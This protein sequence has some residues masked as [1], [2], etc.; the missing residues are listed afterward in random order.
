MS[1]VEWSMGVERHIT[2][3]KV[4]YCEKACVRAHRA[5]PTPCIACHWF[6]QANWCDS[7][8]QIACPHILL[9]VN[10]GKVHCYGAHIKYN[11]ITLWCATC[12]TLC[13]TFS[14]AC[15]VGDHTSASKPSTH[16]HP[17]LTHAPWVLLNDPWVW[18]GIAPCLGCQVVTKLVCGF[19]VQHQ[20]PLL[21]VIHSTKPI[22]VIQ[23]H[24]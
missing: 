20:L 13:G 6:H 1:C 11:C 18:K 24:K 5:T 12:T 19:T 17:P 16:T 9:G 10:K 4:P 22:H 14:L 15:L 7:T 21:L 8:T 23:P 3:C 2:M